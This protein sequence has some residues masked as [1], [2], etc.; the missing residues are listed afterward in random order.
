MHYVLRFIFKTIKNSFYYY[1]IF[2]FLNNQINK[3]YFHDNMVL[4]VNN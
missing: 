2:E 1:D 4:T 3:K